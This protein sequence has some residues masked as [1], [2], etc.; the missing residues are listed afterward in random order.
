[1]S[2]SN[3]S[4]PWKFQNVAPGDFCGWLSQQGTCCRD[5]SKY[6]H[7]TLECFDDHNVAYLVS[8]SSVQ[9]A[10]GRWV[11]GGAMS[12]VC[13]AWS[14]GGRFL[15]TGSG[16]HE[17]ALRLFDLQRKQFL[18]VFGYHDDDLYNR[19][20]SQSGK[21]LASA[22]RHQDPQLKLWKVDWLDIDQLDSV[23]HSQRTLF[24][25]EELASKPIISMRQVA[26]ISR[27]CNH[28]YNDPYELCGSDQ[29][30]YGFHAVDINRA[31]SLLIT[32]ASLVNSR[33]RIVVLSIP[34]LREAF[35]FEI[36]QRIE[37]IGWSCDSRKVI[38][39]S[40][41][42]KA[43]T[44][45][46]IDPGQF[47]SPTANELPIGIADICKPHPWRSICAFSSGR[48]W[49][50]DGHTSIGKISV[51]DLESLGSI[52]ELARCPPVVDMT[53]S[54]DGRSLYALCGDGTKISCEIDL[55]AH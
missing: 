53:W 39:C 1:M 51:I 3:V 10:D 4:S 27:I 15:V 7:H 55:D 28:P 54:R 41:E 6:P 45:G 13:A 49:R 31:N 34:D 29:K 52:S 36:E 47:C 44:Y 2:K 42:S 26:E 43:F 32:F 30:L 22:S 24:A 9:A 12:A 37:S 23:D 35:Q 40:S 16:N 17:R 46:P 19:C 20:W 25:P 11:E 48:W 33:G 8:D 21:Y 50:L 38:F 18:S 5:G 14:P